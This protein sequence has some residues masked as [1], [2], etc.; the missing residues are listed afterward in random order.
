MDEWLTETQIVRG[1][2]LGESGAWTALCDMYGARLWRYVARL[3]GSDEAAVA[4]VFQ[5]T[6]LAVARA[7]RSL[8]DGS[9]LWAWLSTIGHNQAA[10]Y[11]RKR[12]R[13]EPL[14]LTDD[15]PNTLPP[16][17]EL[18]CLE[19]SIAAVR[20]LL[21][22]MTAEHVAVLTAKYVDGHSV[23][24]IVQLLGGTT[25]SVRSR[26]ARARRDFRERY[27]AR[28]ADSVPELDHD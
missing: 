17:E 2:Q 14:S 19:E 8:S 11:W 3:I 26:L 24:E 4:D 18:L 7:G 22:E 21:S 25:E 20:L 5:E 15:R 28:Y 16:P 1:L 9:R 10:L 27:E 13:M 12:F 6:M 23:A